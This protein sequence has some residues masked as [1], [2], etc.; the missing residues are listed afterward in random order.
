LENVNQEERDKKVKE[1]YPAFEKNIC[2]DVLEYGKTLK[3]LNNEEVLVFDIKI[4]KCKNCGIPSTLEI[5]VK[6]SVLKDYSAGK[7]GMD[8]ALTKLSI[9]KGA[10]Q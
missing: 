3:S 6:N 9:K 8:V 7:L 4:T 10:L 5:S 1:L 2:E